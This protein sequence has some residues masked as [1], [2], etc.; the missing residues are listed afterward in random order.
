M[1][2]NEQAV[3]RE[4]GLR[5][6][7]QVSLQGLRISLKASEAVHAS[8]RSAGRDRIPVLFSHPSEPSIRLDSATVPCEGKFS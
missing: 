3:D 6:G 5:K 2:S 4:Q 7:P 8:A 1:H